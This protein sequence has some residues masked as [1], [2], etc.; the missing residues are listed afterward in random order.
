VEEGRKSSLGTPSDAIGKKKLTSHQF[1]DI[2]F[3][4]FVYFSAVF[5]VVAF[6]E[7]CSHTSQKKT[8]GWKGYSF[9]AARD[10]KAEM[11]TF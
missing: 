11:S 8:D 7:C 3:I 5:L 6:C 10:I 4:F 1:K 9:P 2:V